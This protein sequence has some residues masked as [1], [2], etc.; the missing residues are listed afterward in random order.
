MRKYSHKL[1]VEISGGVQVKN[2]L[3]SLSLLCGS[4]WCLCDFPLGLLPRGPRLSSLA[5]PMPMAIPALGLTYSTVLCGLGV[6]PRECP[7]NASVG[8]LLGALPSTAPFF[9]LQFFQKKEFPSFEGRT[10]KL[11]LYTRALADAFI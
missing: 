2:P 3:T 11:G 6:K 5:I 10:G 8:G 1:H 7:A 9:C 4:G